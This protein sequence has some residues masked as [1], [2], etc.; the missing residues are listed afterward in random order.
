MNPPT[1]LFLEEAKVEKY[2]MKGPQKQFAKSKG[3]GK[4]NDTSFP[5]PG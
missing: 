1:V 5:K 2:G 4:R 3:T